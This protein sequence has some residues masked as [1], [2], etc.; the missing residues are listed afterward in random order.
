MNKWNNTSQWILIAIDF[1]A[2]SRKKALAMSRVLPNDSHDGIKNNI[3]VN[4]K[5]KHKNNG[6]VYKVLEPDYTSVY[7][8]KDT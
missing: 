2:V 8:K 7:W 4:M 6:I 5:K 1:S 3:L